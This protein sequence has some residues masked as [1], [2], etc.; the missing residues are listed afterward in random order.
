MPLLTRLGLPLA[1]A[2]CVLFQACVG[3]AASTAPSAAAPAGQPPPAFA[4][5]TPLEW[6][7]R[8]ARSEMARQGDKMFFD[9]NP[10]AKWSYTAP[11][12]GLSLMRLGEYTGDTAMVRYGERTATSFVA[13]DGSIPAYKKDEYNIDLIA[14][15]KVLVRAWADGDRSPALRAAIEQ[16]RDQMRTHPRTSEGGFWHKQR[17]PNQMWLDGLFMASPFL[18]HYAQAFG[19]RP[20]FDDVAK[21]II[22]M[23]KHAFDPATGLYFHAWDEARTQPWANKQ[24]GD[25]PS[26]WS[27][28][29]GWYAMAI[30]DV[31]EYLPADHPDLP[32]LHEILNR[33]A[34]G[35][36]RWQDPAT[37]LWWQV[38]DQ[39]SRQGN[40]LEGTGSSMFVYALAKG[41]NLGALDRARYEPALLKGYAGIIRDLIRTEP[42]GSI[43]LTQCCEVAGLGGMGKNGHPRDGSF[44]YYVSEPV[45]IND[46]KGVAPFISVGVEFER[47]YGRR[48]KATS[49]R[50]SAA[51]AFTARG[52]QDY[53]AAQARI[54]A[55]AFP[56]RDFPITEFGAK[57]GEDAPANANTAALRDAIAAAN[58]AGGGRVVVPPGV[59]RTGAVHL[60][61]NVNLHV[62]K[63]ATLLFSTNPADY[64]LVQT[65]WEGV[66][67]MNYSALIYAFEQ[68]NIAV[69]GEGTLDGGATAADWWSWNKKGEGAAQKQKVARDRLVAL[70][71]TDTPVSKRV[72]GDG[73]FLRPN[74]VQPYRCKNVLIEGVTILRSPMWILH[75]AFCQNVTVRGVTVS[76][77]GGNNDG[78]DPES[79]QDVL[80]ENC[81]FDTGDD[82]IAIKSGRN[83]DGRRVPIP[84]SNIIV[85]GCTMKDGHGGVVLGSECSAGIRNVFVENC[86]MDS[87]EL[88]RA[89]RFKNN[90]VRGGVLENVFMRD[91]KIG[92]VVEAVVTIDLLYEEGANGKFMPTVRNVQLDRVEA[93]AAPRLFYIRGFD[94]ATIEDIRVSDSVFKGLTQAE[95]LQHAGAISLKNVRLE[96]ANLKPGKNSVPAPAPKPAL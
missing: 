17:Y 92:K 23:D 67:L 74:F 27:R 39:G 96:P 4:G 76:S 40:Y 54:K 1:T 46:H 51:P 68:E 47:L 33:V 38:T 77:H 75:P 53:E 66:E 90:A 15:G 79:S 8:F 93:S 34:A 70:A 31:L 49:S 52:W 73:G 84:S 72:F 86:T 83:G 85:R 26:F 36:V 3:P 14:P 16:L 50:S 56:A 62:S 9:T 81:V 69:T 88:D 37:G 10:Q 58:K 65:R 89:L 13:S 2:A 48:A 19:E 21:Q 28:A 60:K 29:I 7:A 12:V 35:I 5:A 71:E 87:P 63:G 30:V 94:G 22:L 91:V 24:T 32:R 42:D 78:C 57:A 80:I 82:C 18:A 20:L 59:W 64:P 45:V 95:V 61:S 44:E 41:I 11:L 55:P 43:S 6:S 25:S